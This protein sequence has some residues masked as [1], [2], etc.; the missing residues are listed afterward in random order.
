M[1]RVI[2]ELSSASAHESDKLAVLG[3]FGD[4]PTIGLVA[5]GAEHQHRETAHFY[6]SLFAHR[7]AALRLILL[8]DPE[9]L[10]ASVQV[11]EKAVPEQ[12]LARADRI[13]LVNMDCLEPWRT[14]EGL[15]HPD[16]KHRH[17]RL[18]VKLFTHVLFPHISRIILLDN[19][20]I[21]VS[22]ILEL[23]HQFDNFAPQ[24][25]VSAAVDQ[26]FVA[27]TGRRKLLL[28]GSRVRIFMPKPPRNVLLSE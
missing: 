8:G 4:L 11:L 21:V 7:S 22:D 12:A 1:N 27:E 6:R 24:E 14:L 16:T 5:Y 2:H 13:R 17:P 9:G 28:G 19:D 18:F 25:L 10:K 15:I 20:L 23:W 3:A 26:R